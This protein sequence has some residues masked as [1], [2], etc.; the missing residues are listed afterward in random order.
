M[1]AIRRA[2]CLLATLSCESGAY[3][4]FSWELAGLFDHT[5]QDR[6]RHRARW[7]EVDSDRVSLSATHYFNPVVE[8]TGPLALAAFFDPRTHLS[9]T[10]G[11]ARISDE[12]FAGPNSLFH[13]QAKEEVSDYSLRGLYLFAESKWYAGGRYARSEGERRRS[14]SSLSSGAGDGESSSDLED[15]GVFAGKYFGMGATRLELSL[16]Q[17]T[18]QNDVSTRQYCF[19]GRL[20]S[21]T[22]HTDE[23]TIDTPRLAVMHVRRFRAATYALFGEI[24]EERFRDG[25]SDGVPLQGGGVDSPRIYFVGGELYPVPTIG[26]RLGYESVDSPDFEFDEDTFSIGASWFVRRNVGLELTLSRHD[27]DIAFSEDSPNTNR[28]AL[29][30]IGRL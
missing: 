16:E 18:T 27:T 4:D 29:R 21:T 26:V 9:V 10:A 1:G 15:Y 24:S 7:T 8:G 19:D 22:S 28:V 17:S 12:F 20:C 25:T 14:F 13:Q 6:D 23:S 11:E 2:L 5:E 3:A 30:V